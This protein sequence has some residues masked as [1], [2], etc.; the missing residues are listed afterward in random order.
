LSDNNYHNFF[1]IIIPTYLL[2]KIKYQFKDSNGKAVTRLMDKVPRPYTCL[3]LKNG[4]LLTEWMWNPLD[5][6]MQRISLD[7]FREPYLDK[8]LVSRFLLQGTKT[9]YILLENGTFVMPFSK[10]PIQI[11]VNGNIYTF[12]NVYPHLEYF[13]NGKI[14]DTGHQE[15]TNMG[16]GWRR[17]IT[18]F[19]DKKVKIIVAMIVELDES[20]GS[21]HIQAQ[22]SEDR[23]DTYEF[24]LDYDG[25]ESI[26]RITIHDKEEKV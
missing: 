21:W 16:F 23:K 26:L 11:E 1:P 14:E 12:D 20:G 9:Q 24:E 19:D 4:G 2:P 15:I 18:L 7:K 5:G 3:F 25:E 10:T 22:N 17:D 6:T 13:L 8:G